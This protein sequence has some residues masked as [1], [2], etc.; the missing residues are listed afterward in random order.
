M[1]AFLSKL[2]A[3]MAFIALA[4]SPSLADPPPGG[5]IAI[6]PKTSSGEYDPALPAFVNAATEALSTKGFTILDDTG[7]AAYVA[8]LILSRADVGTG[9]GKGS[10]RTSVA[11]GGAPGVGAG[12]TIPLSTGQSQLVPLQ[13]TQIELRIHKRGEPAVV[14]KAAAVTVRQLGTRRATTDAVAADL[15]EALLRSY[16]AQPEDIVG[17]P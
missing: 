4:G 1:R 11:P 10:A 7:H 15:S 16:P 5:T 9:L 13:R 6:E 3:A 12:V 17:V 2:T 8:E 14:W